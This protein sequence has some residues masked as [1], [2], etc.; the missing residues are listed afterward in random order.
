MLKKFLYTFLIVLAT[1]GFQCVDLLAASVSANLDKTSAHVHEEIHLTI[2]VEDASGNI[3]APRIQGIDGFDIFYT[4]RASHLSFINGVSSSSVDF[5]YVLMP[6]KSGNFSLPPIE[7]PVGGQTFRTEPVQVQIL[8][9][10]DSP[11]PASVNP[12]MLPNYQP[13][14]PNPFPVAQQ[15]VAAP[16]PSQGNN[17][18]P[19]MGDDN[20]YVVA[21]TDKTTAYPNE[22]VLLTYSLYTRYDTRYEGFKDEPEVSGFWIEEFPLDQNAPREITVVNGKKYMKADVKK[23]ALFPTAPSDYTIKPGVLKA[24]VRKD[25]QSSIFDDFFNDSFF[26]GGGFFSRREDVLLTPAPIQ[27]KIQPFPESGKPK[28][29]Q[30]AVGS[31]RLSATVDK[32]SLKQDEPVTLSVI[33][34][35]EGN[36]ETLK[37]PVVP[38]VDGFRTYDGDANHQ[39]FKTGDRIGGRKTF[40]VVFIPTQPGRRVIPSLEMSFFNPW[41]RQYQTLKTQEFVLDVAKS[42]TVFTLPTA[43]GTSVDLKK[44]IELEKKDIHFIQENLASTDWKRKVAFVMRLLLVLNGALMGLILFLFFSQQRADFFSRNIALKRRLN[45]LRTAENQLKKVKSLMKAKEASQEIEYFEGVERV[46]MGYLADKFNLS[47]LG[48]TRDVL[49]NSLRHAVSDR[50]DLLDKVVWVFDTCDAARF[51]RTSVK[52]EEKQKVNHELNEIIHQLEKIL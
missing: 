52:H 20:I 13:P 34:E 49:E 18:P 31:F 4:G 11:D 46:M 35:G 48:I 43:P 50:T 33:I 45:A 19:P 15:P 14:A 10:E 27:L 26:S 39:L 51:A 41:T 28:N 6:I 44:D 8:Q 47:P 29:F 36:I 1:S 16:V 38:Q 2:R 37:K 24:S 40:E 12:P 9:G 5:N 25:P 42:D 22:Q 30:G 3:Q 32:T 7:I 17:A 21:H 23:Y